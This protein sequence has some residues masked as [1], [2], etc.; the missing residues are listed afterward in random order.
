MHP[1]LPLFI[2]VGTG[3]LLFLLG[4]LIRFRRKLW[5]AG[6]VSHDMLETGNRDR[7]ASVTGWGAISLGFILCLVGILRTVFP[8]H[9]RYFETGGLLLFLAVTALVVIKARSFIIQR[10]D[11]HWQ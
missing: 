9:A 7:F 6:G 5:L 8:D 3:V 10:F 4:Y 1:D 11:D 2:L